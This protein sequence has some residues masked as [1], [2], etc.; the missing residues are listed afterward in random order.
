MTAEYLI[1]GQAPDQTCHTKNAMYYRTLLSQININILCQIIY[2]FSK[3][4]CNKRD[5]VQRAGY[6]SKVNLLSGFILQQ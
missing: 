3:L 2:L 5:N 4:L 1:P 6:C